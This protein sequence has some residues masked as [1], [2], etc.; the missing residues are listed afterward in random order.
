MDII[1]KH[2]NIVIALLIML[3]FIVYYS[4][5]N[6]CVNNENFVGTSLWTDAGCWNDNVTARAINSPIFSAST[7]EECQAYAE[8]NNASVIGM[9][10]GNQC[11]IGN[12]TE[13]TKYGKASGTCTPLGAP[14]V[15][16]VYTRQ[17]PN[18]QWRDKQCWN[19]NASQPA[20]SNN[21]PFDGT[22]GGCQKIAE[23]NYSDVFGVQNGKCFINST[24][25]TYTKYGPTSTCPIF[26]DNLVNHVY[27]NPAIQPSPKGW[28]D[29]GCWLDNA[30]RAIPNAT[31]GSNYSVETCK[32]LAESLG[33]NVFGLQAGGQCFTGKDANYSKFGK[34]TGQCAKLGGP[35][36]NH[37]YTA[38]PPPPPPPIVAKPIVK[39]SIPPPA[40]AKPPT[41]PPAVAKPPTPP[42]AVAK[43]PIITSPIPPLAKPPVVPPAQPTVPPVIPS[44]Q[45]TVI[46]PAQPTVPPVIPPAQPVQQI[47]LQSNDN[48]TKSLIIVAVVITVAFIIAVSIILY[49]RSRNKN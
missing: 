28:I 35:W 23:S 30:T 1:E 18:T 47:A 6:D 7:V 48:T 13:F 5:K 17:M 15:N 36:I 44:A 43:P 11:L 41:P 14:Y 9:Q 19:D 8:Q 38:I 20:I 21:I 46:P 49:R 42:P 3:L 10:D 31:S 33:H 16:H 45:P 27:H 32:Q 29:Q 12:N 25:D 4:N 39:P 24:S 34:A 2:I 26:G 22:I 37:V 40:V